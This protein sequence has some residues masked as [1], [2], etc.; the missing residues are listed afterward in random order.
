MPET[1]PQ[2]DL[3]LP[4]VIE[5]PQKPGAK[6]SEFWLSLLA[7]G[8]GAATAGGLFGDG[9]ALKIAG[10]ASAMLGSLGYTWSRTTLKG[11]L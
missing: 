1:E 5:A 6:T 7:V 8:I 11:S 9:T 4:Q 10:V 2:P 3:V